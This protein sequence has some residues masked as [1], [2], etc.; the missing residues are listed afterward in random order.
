MSGCGRRLITSVSRCVVG[1]GSGNFLNVA[2][3][4]KDDAGR[5]GL[6][7][8]SNKSESLSSSGFSW[9]I[10]RLW[11]VGCWLGCSLGSSFTSS[12]TTTGIGSSL[13]CSFSSSTVG[14]VSCW[15]IGRSSH[16]VVTD[17]S[18]CRPFKASSLSAIN[19]SMRC[20]TA[21]S[22]LIGRGCLRRGCTS[23]WI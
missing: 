1:S 18:R 14:A 2:S 10:C 20:A 16:R 8:L 13:G 5:S 17:L 15:Y 12:F 11:A 9:G 4:L 21:E 7:H 22:L 6:V 3:G 23:S 19:P